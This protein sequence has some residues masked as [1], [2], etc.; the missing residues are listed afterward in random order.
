MGAL[1]DLQKKQVS[2]VIFVGLLLVLA[3]GI[4]F[5]WQSNGDGEPAADMTPKQHALVQANAVSLCT[6]IP[7]FTGTISCE[8]FEQQPNVAGHSVWTNADG[9]PV[10]RMDLITTANL[11]V[12]EPIES[13]A[14][15][16]KI[17]PEIKNSGR[18]DWAEPKGAWS[19]AIIT[20]KNGDQ[21]LLFEDNGVVVIMQSNLLDRDTQLNLADQALRALRKAKPAISSAGAATPK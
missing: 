14:W 21:E 16:D 1:K 8:D 9:V 6:V 2:N 19:K 13:K 7:N 17:L 15:F 3:A 20:V 18:E 4:A 10:V 5:W 11:S 12:S